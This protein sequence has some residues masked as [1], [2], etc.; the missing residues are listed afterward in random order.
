MTFQEEM[1]ELVIEMLDEFGAPGFLTRSGPA[2]ET[3][4]KRTE[5]ME[6]SSQAPLTIPVVAS[7]GPIVL[8]D[9]D[10][11]E[12]TKSVATLREK[13][14]QGDKL[15]WGALSYVIGTVTALPLQGQI[16]AYIAEVA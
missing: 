11:R 1:V 6:T 12:V 14:A 8:K 3:F 15:T 2:I 9:V 4:N 10:G 13:P 7:V 16:V 5:R